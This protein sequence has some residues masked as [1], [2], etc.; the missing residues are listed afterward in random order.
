MFI[1]REPISLEVFMSSSPSESCGGTAVF[2]GHVRNHHQGKKV[3]GLFYECY[4]S[5][6]EREI[7]KIIAGVKAGTGAHEIHVIHRIGWLEVGDIAVII[8]A[9]GAHR[10]EAFAAC[11]AVLECVKKDAPIWKKEKY[12]NGRENWIECACEL[13][14]DQ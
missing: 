4:E 7:A 14:S 2:I 3:I 13:A 6:A 12:E 9:S 1:T 8:S 10:D 5:M 11:R